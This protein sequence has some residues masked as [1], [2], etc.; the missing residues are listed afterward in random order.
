MLFGRETV[1]TSELISLK[2]RPGMSKFFLAI[3]VVGLGT[4]IGLFA[5]VALTL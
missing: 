1:R 3:I 2:V 4:L 5:I